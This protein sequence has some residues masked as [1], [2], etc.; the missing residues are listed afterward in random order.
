MKHYTETELDQAIKET[1]C[2]MVDSTTPPPLEESWLRFEK[3]LKDQQKIYHKKRRNLLFLRLVASAGVIII[4][5]G[6][7]TV[8]FPGKARALGEK[9]LYTIENLLGDTQINVRTEY[10]HNEPTGQLPPPPNE[11]FIEVPIEQERIVSLDEA[12]TV[13]PFPVAVPQYVPAGYNLEQVEFQPM[14]EPVARIRLKYSRHDLKYFELEQT[15]VP[16]GY[17]QGY[18]YDIEDA[19]VQDVT[20]GKNTA[21]LILFKND[22]IRMTWINNSVL[23]TL[24]GK[25]SQEE[26]L[27]V[28]ESMK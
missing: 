14:I 17:V 28:A 22:R 13:S 18:G 1:V 12:I 24:E 20:V 8:S 26:A 15:N 5:A 7:F 3:K 6:V 21:N 16:A 11:G 25:I 27:K 2:E 9:I 23:F 19:T 10:R 4:L